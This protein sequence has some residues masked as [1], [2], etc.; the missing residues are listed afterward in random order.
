MKVRGCCT[1]VAQSTQ[2]MRQKSSGHELATILWT[3]SEAS[4]LSPCIY[5][6]LRSSFTLIGVYMVTFSGELRRQTSSLT[7]LLLSFTMATCGSRCSSSFQASFCHLTFS[8][9]GGILA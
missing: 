8:R 3:V 4:V 1:K 2:A 9:R 6:T 5:A 7:H